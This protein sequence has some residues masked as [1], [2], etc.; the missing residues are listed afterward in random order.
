MYVLLRTDISWY[1][2][3]YNMDKSTNTDLAVRAVWAPSWRPLQYPL[4]SPWDLFWNRLFFHG[5]IGENTG[6]HWKLWENMGNSLEN[7]GKYG[8]ISEDHGNIM[9]NSWENHLEI[10]WCVAVGYWNSACFRGKSSNQMGCVYHSYVKL[11]HPQL[12]VAPET[13]THGFRLG[14]LGSTYKNFPC[15]APALGATIPINQ[16]HNKESVDCQN[17]ANSTMMQQF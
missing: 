14:C 7:L 11:P 6:N 5:K 17:M 16:S 4:P 1:V 8:K 13:I 15:I 2:Y 10:F 12:R 9:P 3:S